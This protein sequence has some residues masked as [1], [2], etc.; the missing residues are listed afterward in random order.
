MNKL[1]TDAK[2]QVI[3]SDRGIEIGGTFADKSEDMGIHN[4]YFEVI[5]EA[6]HAMK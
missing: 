1:K 3:T 4:T 6:T 2:K 5:E